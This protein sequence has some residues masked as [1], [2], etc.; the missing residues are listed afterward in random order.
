MF[1]RAYDRYLSMAAAELG[2]KTAFGS[3]GV[4]SIRW[5]ILGCAATAV[6]LALAFPYPGWWPLALVALVP[7]VVTAMRSRRPRRLVWTSYL[8]SLAWWLYMLQWLTPVTVPGYV[9]LCAYMAI[10]M[11]VALLAMRAVHRQYRAA[12]VLAVPLVWVSLEMVRTYLLAGGFGWFQ[13]GHALAAFRSDQR[14]ATLV[15]VADVFGEHGVSFLAAMTSGLVVDLLTRPWFG[16][17]SALTGRRRTVWPSLALWA[18]V[19][20][21]AVVYGHMRISQYDAATAGSTASGGASGGPSG[22]VAVAVI[23]TNVPQSNKDSPTA[24]Q[25]EADWLRLFELT[26]E[27]VEREPELQLIVWPESVTPRPINPQAV[28][29]AQQY[30]LDWGNYHEDVAGLANHLHVPLLVG[31]S[32]GED[33]QVVAQGEREILLATR[34][35]NSVHLYHGDGRQDERRYD[36]IHRVPFG[37][38][39]PWIESWPWLLDLFLKHLTPY[40]FDYSLD[41]GVGL[42]VFEIDRAGGEPFRV[43]T[44]ICFEDT[45]SRLCRQMVYEPSGVKRADGLVNVTNDAWFSGWSQ[46]RQ[47]LQIATLRCIENRVPMARSVNTGV[48]GFI[49]SLGR[50]GALNADGGGALAGGSRDGG[51]HVEGVAIGRMVFD[52]RRTMYGRWGNRPMAGVA[53]CTGFWVGA[54]PL[55]ARSRRRRAGARQVRPG[56][57]S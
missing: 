31:A 17:R 32:A 38:Y 49:D 35:Y 9:G 29:A 34:H 41:A 45:V 2:V 37:E 47:H 48:S 28:L 3:R 23:Q 27:A 20:A 5:H 25:T 21:A 6:L 55:V 4:R 56:E 8:V 7:A 54:T 15:Q 51:Q 50:I 12:A 30:G 14:A 46:R 36:K 13:L 57:I 53:V 22:G 24:E 19:M 11:P 16:R 10:Y 52:S 1:V 39:V 26:L 42:T 40:G 18:V 44:P 43:A 33:W